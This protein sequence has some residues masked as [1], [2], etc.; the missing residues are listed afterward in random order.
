M[1]VP[2]G[3]TGKE[4][5]WQS[6]IISRSSEL[7]W[8]LVV[9]PHIQEIIARSLGARWC[10]WGWGP[11]FTCMEHGVLDALIVNVSSGSNGLCAGGNDGQKFIY[12]PMPSE[13]KQSPKSQKDSTT[14]NFSLSTVIAA[15][16]LAYP[17][18]RLHLKLRLGFR[19]PEIPLLLL[20]TQLEQPP[21]E[22]GVYSDKFE[23]R[24]TGVF[25]RL[26]KHMGSQ[27]RYQGPSFVHV[28][29]KS[30]SF[31]ISLPEDKL[32]L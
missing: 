22:K 19:E 16:A 4:Y 25:A 6:C 31:H 29:L 7:T 8:S 24:G 27:P 28:G 26:L 30:L 23:T 5:L 12:T 9:T 10:R 13:D 1:T 14:S 2:S 20:F 11:D 3:L 32:L 17:V 15:I 21:Q 18:H